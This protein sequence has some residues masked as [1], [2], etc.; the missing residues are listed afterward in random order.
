V[1]KVVVCK[2]N[3]PFLSKLVVG[4]HHLL[5]AGR[6][7]VLGI[8]PKFDNNNTWNIFRTWWLKSVSSC[9][10]INMFLF[11]IINL[12]PLWS[13]ILQMNIENGVLV[14]EIEWIL[15]LV[16]LGMMLLRR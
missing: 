8:N 15:I 13:F 3:T 4:L 16:I 11:Q 5:V 14:G 2:L 12:G 9:E 6:S 7:P 1:L 10:F